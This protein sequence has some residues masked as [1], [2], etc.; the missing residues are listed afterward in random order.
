MWGTATICPP[1]PAALEQIEMAKDTT[2]YWNPL[3]AEHGGRWAPVEGLA[4]A[5]EGAAEHLDP[6]RRLQGPS[7]KTDPGTV[8]DQ[9][10]SPLEHFHHGRVVPHL[11]DPPMQD[12]AAALDLHRLAV[13]HAAD[14]AD[15]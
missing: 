5:A 13:A 14:P 2:T 15:E 10:C 11:E 8:E 9:T 6:H 3:A 4:A 12:V 1:R 7:Q